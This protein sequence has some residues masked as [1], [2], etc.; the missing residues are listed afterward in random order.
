[1]TGAQGFSGK[2]FAG[3]SLTEH[4][5]AEGEVL[6]TYWKVRSEYRWDTGLAVGR[7]LA[8]LKDG[9]ILGIRCP[10]CERTLV[11]PRA[12]CEVCFVPLNRWVQL[13]DRGGVNTFSVSFVNWDASRRQVPEV[14][15]VIEIGGAS[16]GMA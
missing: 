11:P 9:K 13:E 7:F 14:P 6:H 16:P 5:L 3:T 8:G 1:M 15:A 12:F 4:T 2:P 10:R